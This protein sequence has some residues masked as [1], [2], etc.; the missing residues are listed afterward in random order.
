MILVHDIEAK[1]V[2]FTIQMAVLNVFSH[3][4]SITK[5]M[6]KLFRKPHNMKYKVMTWIKN[7]IIHSFIHFWK[8]F[9]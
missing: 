4:C 7:S 3:Y 9:F 5:Q 6:I 1:S 2:L 8:S